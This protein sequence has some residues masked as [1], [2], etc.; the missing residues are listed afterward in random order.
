M[1]GGIINVPS[2]VTAR[3]PIHFAVATSTLVIFFTCIA[4]TCIQIQLGHIADPLI[5]ILFASGSIIGAGVGAN[6]APKIP[7]KQL[8]TA[9]GVFLFLI[10]LI[11]FSKVFL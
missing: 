7:S 5:V 2:L 10:S 1:G 3:L 4:A 9:F 11:M 8:N 6:L